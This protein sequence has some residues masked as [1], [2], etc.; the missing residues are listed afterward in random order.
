MA[1]NEYNLDSAETVFFARELEAV[2][3]KTY[4]RKKPELKFLNG[5]I[6]VSTE[7]GAGATSIVW[8]SYDKTGIAKIISN[9]ADDLPMASVKGEEHITPVRDFGI[10]YDYSIKDIKASQRAR[11]NLDQKKAMASRDGSDSAINKVAIFGDAEFKLPGFLTNPNITRGDVALNA[12]S[13]STLWTNKTNLEI[14]K[15]LNALVN[16]IKS[17]TNGVEVPDTL[18][19]PIEQYSLISST[20]LQ[21]GSDTT[22]LEFFKRSHPYVT[23]IDW[24]AELKNAGDFVSGVTGDLMVA[25][26]RDP[27]HLTLEIPD[28]YFQ[29]P[30]EARNLT[31]VVNT[32]ATTGGV[33][34]YYPLSVAIGGNI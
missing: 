21:A 25:Y 30:P 14:L 13:T 16:G 10:A 18:L 5:L 27:D 32:V 15:D 3:A 23:L 28:P 22:I 7:A 31:Y 6:P 20:P 1:V 4:D 12:G 2:K 11:K 24:V 19:L 29:M 26:K 17:L 8:H 33:L 34:I 9:Y